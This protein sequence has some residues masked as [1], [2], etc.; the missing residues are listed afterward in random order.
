VPHDLLHSASGAQHGLA[1]AAAA[2]AAARARAV[3]VVAVQ[4]G[5]RVRV[6]RA[7][8]QVVAHAHADLA[9]DVHAVPAHAAA[10]PVKAGRSECSQG[11][12][13][14]RTSMPGLCPAGALDPMQVKH[15]AQVTV[16]FCAV[17]QAH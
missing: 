6:S 17:K 4:R 16:V 14:P 12:A 11:T 15:V 3:R 1:R 7:R 9:H 2:T 5:V 13:A 8:L 10:T